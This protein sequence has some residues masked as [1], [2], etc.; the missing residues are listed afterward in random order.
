MIKEFIYPETIEEAIKLIKRKDITTKP[1]AG[2]SYFLSKNIKNVEALVDITRLNLSYIKENDTSVII[3]ATTIL[4]DIMDDDILLKNNLSSLIEACHK[5]ADTTLLNQMTI[6]GNI[7]IN[8]S[9]AN[10][11]LVLVNYNAKIVLIGDKE[12]VL[13]IVEFMSKRN[14]LLKNNLIKEVIL[15]KKYFGYSGMFVKLGATETDYPWIILAILT[16]IE[17][18]LI[19]DI[20]IS[21]G[22]VTKTLMKLSTLEKNLLNKTDADITID[23]IKENIDDI[24]IKP[25][26]KLEK[27][28]QEDLIRNLLFESLKKL[29][30]G[31]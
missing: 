20:R 11:P 26:F 8:V 12:E 5:S 1:I 21:I 28:Y 30:G 4:S 17:N 2:G 19:K 10:I 29:M 18:G 27:W 7:A 3:G 16:K 23:F 9:W 15:P 22:G 6:G 14:E 24:I 13:P 31:K 25:D